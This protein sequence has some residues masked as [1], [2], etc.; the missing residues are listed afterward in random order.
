MNAE[1]IG[2]IRL[3]RRFPPEHRDLSPDC[4]LVGRVMIYLPR[5]NSD[6]IHTL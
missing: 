1:V 4:T 3:C 2:N 6:V 5:L